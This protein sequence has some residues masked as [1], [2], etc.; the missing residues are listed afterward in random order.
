MITPSW[1]V[2]FAA[3]MATGG[4]LVF[5]AVMLSS[6][7]YERRINREIQARMRIPGSSSWDE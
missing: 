3:G 7:L 4:L 5:G 6:W 2:A 1:L